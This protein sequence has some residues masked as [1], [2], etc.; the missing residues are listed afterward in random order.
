MKK[1]IIIF[2]LIM[3]LLLTGCNV[4]GDILEFIEP[5]TKPK[6]KQ[7]KIIDL[8]STS[9]PYAVVVNNLSTAR[10]YQ[11][12]LQDA[13]IVYEFMTEGGITR[14]LALFQD[15]KTK[16]IGSIRSA[17]HYFLDYV[18]ENDAILVHHGQSTYAQ[19]D[20]NSLNIDRIVV[21]ETKTGWRDKKMKVN[22]EH[23]LFTSIEAIE[24]G[25]KDKRV[26]KEKETLLNYKVDVI[27]I[28]NKEEAIIADK[29]E[30]E[31]SYIL[32][33][34][35]EYDSEN[36][37][38]KR[39]INDKPHND[40][41][42]EEQ[43]TFKNIIVVQIP[44]SVIAGDNKGRQ[45]LLNIGEFDGYY[46]TNGYAVPIKAKKDSRTSATKYKYLNGEEIE[47][48]DGNTFIQIQ[49]TNKKITIE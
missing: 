7:L 29:V 19:Y 24:K 14:F 15:A 12:G 33:N 48:N 36:N 11:S 18:L 27:N 30:M 46:I 45:N 16:R 9:R 39:F 35:Y 38:Y 44:N 37:N 31:Y 32:T 4:K 23:T 2:M 3:I 20:F 6:E 22:S 28:K 49:P 1:R 43:Y 25:L 40:Y 47:V 8:K 41:V 13:Y 17:R 26:T 34:K 42:T 5:L 10:P 21:D